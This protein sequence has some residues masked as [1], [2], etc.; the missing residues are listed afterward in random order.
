MNRSAD[1]QPAGNNKRGQDE[2]PRLEWLTAALGLVLACV[3]FLL[4]QAFSGEAG[5]PDVVSKVKEVTQTRGG[6][7][8]ELR[9]L[10]EGATTAA[11]LRVEGSLK[12]D[13]K[14]VETSET[15][16]DYLPPHSEREAGLFFA[17]DPSGLELVLRAKGY[18]TP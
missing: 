6:F 12:E 1:D 7:V 4:Y 13:N 2:T 9:V 10:N 14:I 15:T 11:G 16:L 18:Q 8:A 17:R 5:S 3:T